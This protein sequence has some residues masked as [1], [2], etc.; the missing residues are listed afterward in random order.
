MKRNLLIIFSFLI[1]SGLVFAIVQMQNVSMKNYKF[2][3]GAG[4]RIIV[5]SG[6]TS[7]N[8]RI[9]PTT[10]RIFDYTVPNGKVLNGILG[11]K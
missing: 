8:I 9:T 5:I 11:E 3:L 6:S 10:A 7:T 2:T 4:D 1:C